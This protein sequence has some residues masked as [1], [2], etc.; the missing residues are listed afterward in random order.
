MLPKD[1]HDLLER[2]R[3]KEKTYKRDIEDQILPFISN[4]NVVFLVGPRRAGKSVVAQRLLAKMPKTTKIRYVNLEDPSLINSLSINLMDSFAA[5]LGRNDTIVFDEVQLIPGWEKWVRAAVDTRKCQIIVTGSSS[6]LLSGEFSSSLGGRGIG[7]QILPF[8]FREFHRIRKKGLDDYLKTGGYPEVVLNPDKKEKLLESYF[9]LALIKDIVT[10]HSV[11]DSVALRNLAFF[12]LTNSGKQ[13]SL[14]KIRATLGLSYDTIRQFLDYLESAFLIFQ[15]PFFS[16][17][18][19]DSLSRPRKIYAFD[20][21]MQQYASKSL[22]EDKGHLA[23]A[24]V[25]IELKRRQYET[26]Y[27]QNSREVDFVAKKKT[28]IWP[29]NVCYSDKIPSREKDGLV[30]F[31]KKNRVSKAT[32]LYAGKTSQI[33]IHNTEIE[34]KNLANWLLENSNAG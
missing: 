8:S 7:F 10:R 24:A 25:A 33:N 21:G 13:I 11:R 22:S 23:E 27:W 17:S 4:K 12:L 6:K 26:F 30:E 9:E 16:H 29:I 3:L 2:W 34:T 15:V 20:L 18:M 31:C 14:K 19:M 5:G 32:I 28:N 1:L